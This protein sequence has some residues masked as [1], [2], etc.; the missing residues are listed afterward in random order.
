[1][2]ARGSPKRCAVMR[3][4]RICSAGW[5]R[6]PAWCRRRYR[7]SGELKF[8]ADVS[9]RITAA[10]TASAVLRARAQPPRRRG[11]R[12]AR[13]RRPRSAIIGRGSRTSAWTSRTSS[14]IASSSCSMK[15]RQTGYSAWNRLFDE[16][17]AT[18]RFKVGGKELPIEPTLKLLQDRDGEAQGRRRRRWRRPSRPTCDL[19]A[20]H[21]HARQGQGDFRPLAR[22]RGCRRFASSLQ[23][24]RARSGRCAGRGR[25]RG[26]SAAVASLLRAQGALVRQEEARALGPQ[27]AAAVRGT[28]PSAGTRRRNRC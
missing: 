25:A 11:A 20:G 21:Q 13:C 10:S 23:P 2:R 9:E 1:M 24:R 22:L 14:T 28:A 4:S 17:I 8:Y 3:R 16:T 5:A 7:R 15:S 6:L 19:R 26:L 18:L 12:A 27:R